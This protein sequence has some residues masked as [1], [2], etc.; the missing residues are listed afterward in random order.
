MANSRFE[1]VRRE[2]KADP[3][4]D[5]F[6]VVRIDGRGFTRFADEHGWRKPS[7]DRAIGLCNEAARAV[8]ADCGD[9]TVAFGV[10]DE[11]SFVFRRASELYGRRTQKIVSTLTSC[12]TANFVLLWPRHFPG[13][14]L[15]RAPVFDGRLV[16]Y[17]DVQTVRDYLA[18]RQVDTHVN[19]QYN[20]AFWALVSSGVTRTDA[21]ARLAGTDAEQKEAMLVEH[22]GR[23]YADL[24]AAHRK[25]SVCVRELVME[26]RTAANGSAFS[27][28]VSTV[29][30]VHDDI[31][32]DAFWSARPDVLEPPSRAKRRR[33]AYAS[34]GA[35]AGTRQSVAD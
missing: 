29:V 24:P 34:S 33:A 22:T 20:T 12:F 7:D 8:M 3:A 14:E 19:N 27:R 30:T 26:P 25:G 21:Q 1:Y 23:A 9:V 17:P 32:G 18:W 11:Y 5:G 6:M 13:V 2:E 28:A 31:I 16:V 15:G 4:A 10:S 35:A